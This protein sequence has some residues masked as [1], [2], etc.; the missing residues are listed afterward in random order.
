MDT[1]CALRWHPLG[2]LGKTDGAGSPQLGHTGASQEVNSMAAA[3]LVP[4]NDLSTKILRSLLTCIKL[5]NLDH[6]LRREFVP[7]AVLRPD[8]IF[9]QK[10]EEHIQSTHCP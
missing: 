6:F 9:Y 4:F 10:L 1:R 2:G 8:T 3:A 7:I 5:Q